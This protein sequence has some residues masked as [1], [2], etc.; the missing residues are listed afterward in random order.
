MEICNCEN[1]EMVFTAKN[2]PAS[3]DY[4][5]RSIRAEEGFKKGLYHSSSVLRG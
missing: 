1:M 3:K 4:G 2:P 5:G